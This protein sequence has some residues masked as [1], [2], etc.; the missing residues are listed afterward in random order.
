M[1]LC[2]WECYIGK[3][4]VLLCDLFVFWNVT[5]LMTKGYGDTF[6][7]HHFDDTDHLGITLESVLI[8]LTM[9]HQ[10]SDIREGHQNGD[11]LLI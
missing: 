5:R 8:L 1:D 10:G 2:I 7:Y 9:C 6:V 11:N 4:H 3:D